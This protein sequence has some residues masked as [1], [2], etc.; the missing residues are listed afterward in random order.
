[1]GVLHLTKFDVGG[2]QH[3]GRGLAQCVQ[4]DRCPC[5]SLNC[6]KGTTL[7]GRLWRN[8]GGSVFNCFSTDSYYL[9]RFDQCRGK[10][11]WLLLL[12]QPADDDDDHDSN[13]VLHLSKC[14]A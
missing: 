9:K 14:V 8:L 6:F 11:L 3:W 5:L 1:V 10:D 4:G 7:T 12:L 2:V 13:D